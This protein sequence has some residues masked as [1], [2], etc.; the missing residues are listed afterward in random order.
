[1]MCSLKCLVIENNETIGAIPLATIATTGMWD[2]NRENRFLYDTTKR[3]ALLSDVYDATSPS[4]TAVSHTTSGNTTY[5]FTKISGS[6]GGEK[7]VRFV[8]R[9]GSGTQTGYV[10]TN[11][12]TSAGVYVA[13]LQAESSITLTDEYQEFS[14]RIAND[15]SNVGQAIWPQLRIPD[16]GVTL[17]IAE[18]NVYFNVGDK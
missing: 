9:V 5:Q 15:A 8:A 17:Y 18:M 6:G 2:A 10:A 16:S 4:K 11:L 13:T 3:S 14:F 7:M 1:M 12:Y